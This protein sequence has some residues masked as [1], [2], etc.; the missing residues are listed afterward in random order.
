[1]FDDDDLEEEICSEV[2]DNDIAPSNYPAYGNGDPVKGARL[3]T[4]VCVEKKT[5][6]GIV[7]GPR[8]QNRE[9]RNHVFAIMYVCF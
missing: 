1:M 3:I 7:M 8:N 5:G 9:V 2:E 4:R 6:P